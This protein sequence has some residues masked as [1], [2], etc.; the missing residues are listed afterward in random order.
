MRLFSVYIIKSKIFSL[1]YDIIF[2]K[3]KKEEE[4]KMSKWIQLY[5]SN[6]ENQYFDRKST[7]IKPKDIL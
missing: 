5:I 4:W 6:P 3:I 2:K 7:V 1:F